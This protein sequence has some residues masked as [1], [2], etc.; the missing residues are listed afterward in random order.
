MEG[1]MNVTSPVGLQ[2]V[3]ID[4]QSANVIATASKHMQAKQYVEAIQALA[5]L[6]S[7]LDVTHPKA[8]LVYALLM[9]ADAQ[10]LAGFPEDAYKNYVIA[11]ELEPD[12]ITELKR[13]LFH[14]LS[15]M[16]TAVDSPTFEQHLMEYFLSKDHD[17]IAVDHLACQILI[18]KYQ[19]RDAEAQIDFTAIIQDEFFVECIT[20]LIM[21]EA[22]IERFLTQL[23]RQVF[24]IALE[25]EFPQELSA[26]VIA[27]AEHA[28]LVEYAFPVSEA[29]RMILLGIRTL[30][31]TDKSS[32]PGSHV[33]QLSLVCIYGM[34][35][36]PAA[37]AIS[38]DIRN[39]GIEAW[40]TLLRGLFKRV[41]L[42]PAEERAL[43]SSV[44]SLADVTEQVSVSVMNQYEENP[45]PRWENIFIADKKVNYLDLYPQLKSRIN[46]PKKFRGQ[47]KC[48]IAGSGTGRQ[49]LW[50]AASCKDITITALDLSRPSLGYALRR[51]KD[52]NLDGQV[53]FLQGDILD[54]GALEE[55]FEIVECVGVLH[56]MESPERGLDTLLPR[57]KSHGILKLGLY[58]RKARETL[59]INAA[60]IEAADA[61]LEDIRSLRGEYMQEIGDFPSLPRD[62]FITSECRDLLCHVQEHQYD[63][64][65]IKSMLD[66][67]GLEFLGFNALKPDIQRA[68]EATFGEASLLDLEKWHEFEQKNP[69]IFKGMYQFHCQKLTEH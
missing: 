60:R 16:Q 12:R 55:T 5:P 18:K 36:S 14:C 23:R 38:D 65:D 54:L 7:T 8:E 51:A 9:M 2:E 42:D 3:K 27:L 59:G 48:L 50:L 64:L 61:T 4:K 57:L 69:F 35:E 26:I 10:R 52:F 6:V 58:S 63:L 47:L 39:A 53:T 25:G 66:K 33:E 28:E 34:Y 67:R 56:H 29:E 45:Y 62:F 1:N 30:L 37:L 68:F 19:L 20:H 15:A 49:P 32:N 44:P 13:H 31:D 21:P 43:V 22:Y 40:P 24:Q 17:N 41:F 11:S 46:K